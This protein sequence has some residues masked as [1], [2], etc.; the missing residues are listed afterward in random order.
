M[1]LTTYNKLP[2]DYRKLLDR[3][4]EV[5]EKGYAPY[6]NFY[7]GAAVLTKSGKIFTGTNI[8]TASYVAICAERSAIANAVSNGEY[9]FVAIAVISKSKYFDVTKIAG[10]C[11]ICRQL[12]YEFSKMS[13][14]DIDVINSTTKKDKIIIAK[15][16]ELNPLSFGPDDVEVDTS[17]YREGKHRK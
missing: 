10:P 16:S 11:G 17:K 5:M 8:E 1:K 6:T 15:I 3:A 9:N 14:H 7:V 13:K 2:K 4:E 12:I